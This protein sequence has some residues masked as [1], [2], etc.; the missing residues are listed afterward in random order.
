[1]G[2][3][4][5]DVGSSKPNVPGPIAYPTILESIPLLQSPDEFAPNWAGARDF[6]LSTGADHRGSRELRGKVDAR[7]LLI[8]FV[9]FNER[10]S[11]WV[12]ERLPKAFITQLKVA[13]DELLREVVDRP[14]VVIDVGAGFLSPFAQRSRQAFVVG[15]DIAADQIAR[16]YD[17]DAR[18]VGTAYQLPIRK[19]VIDVVVSRTLIEHLSE[20]DTFMREVA[21]VLRPGGVAIHL[22]PGRFAPFAILNRILPESIKR[23]LLLL[24]FPESRGL[25][26][27]PAFYDRCTEPNMRQLLRSLDFEVVD[28]RC[29][30][31]QSL[32]YKAFFPLYLLSLA[33]DL[34][35]WRLD[36]R[37]LASQVLIVAKA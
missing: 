35:V 17:V 27:F 4:V 1:M 8:R 34:T 14:G 3:G 26:G 29:Y 12:E 24:A 5:P 19:G 11:D 20:T 9:Q 33:Y 18:L 23:R 30:Y 15:I 16:N 36:I 31:Y 32:Y 2:F 10:W 22:F 21:R 13:Q 28:S 7:S 6:D 37:T 25:L